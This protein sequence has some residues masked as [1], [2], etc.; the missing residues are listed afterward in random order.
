MAS[1]ATLTSALS[2]IVIPHY[3]DT[4]DRLNIDSVESTPRV[5]LNNF[6]IQQ[7]IRTMDEFQLCYYSG[8]IRIESVRT[9][10]RVIACL[11]TLPLS[12]LFSIYTKV[13]RR[14]FER[15]ERTYLAISRNPDNLNEFGELKLANLNNF[16]DKAKV[17]YQIATSALI[18]NIT[19]YAIKRSM[20]KIQQINLGIKDLLDTGKKSAQDLALPL[21]F[22]VIR[23]LYR[24][25]DDSDHVE[26]LEDLLN[27]SEEA[28]QDIAIIANETQ[29]ENVLKEARKVLRKLFSSKSLQ[30]KIRTLDDEQDLSKYEA[31]LVLLSENVLKS[32][33][34]EKALTGIKN[35]IPI[36]NRPDGYHNGF[37]DPSRVEQQQKKNSAR[38]PLLAITDMELVLQ[39]LP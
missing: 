9:G 7:Q 8:K 31:G 5:D 12:L 32:K 39:E 23:E 15:S 19:Y 22:S 10:A 3:D 2:T 13:S 11:A 17:I 1:P 37:R 16:K 14:S 24:D 35:L 27:K 28:S 34:F 21:I 6:Q 33:Q 20:L 18:R 30:R 4:D 38:T 36:K 26:I 25:E 29:L